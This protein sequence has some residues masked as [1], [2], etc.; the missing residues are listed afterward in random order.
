MKVFLKHQDLVLADDTGPAHIA[1]H[2]TG[3]PEVVSAF[4]PY[5]FK[6]E[7]W[8][9]GSRH[10]GVSLTEEEFAQFGEGDVR[11]WDTHGDPV[12]INTIPPERISQEAMKHL[13]HR[14]RHKK[15]LLGAVGKLFGK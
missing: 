11:Y 2:V 3:G 15:S 6:K 10:H 9:S 7:V 13:E 1:A 14:L 5:K 12:V 4:L 8:A